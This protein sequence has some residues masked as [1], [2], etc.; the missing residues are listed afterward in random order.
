M[1]ADLFFPPCAFRPLPRAGIAVF[2]GIF[3]FFSFLAV[4]FCLDWAFVGFLPLH[5][6]HLVFHFYF[7]GPG[8]F[9]TPSIRRFRSFVPCPESLV[10]IFPF[11]SLYSPPE[12][13]FFFTPDS[14]SFRHLSP[15][16]LN[17]P[18]WSPITFSLPHLHRGTTEFFFFAF[19]SALRSRSPVPPFSCPPP[20]SGAP[21]DHLAYLFFSFPRWTPGGGAIILGC[22]GPSSDPIPTSAVGISS[23]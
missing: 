19:F 6:P 13:N 9:F 4:S 3:F 14:F 20:T 22:P 16:H 21:C 17:T 12:F 10:L 15:P 23:A 11:G 2:L 1:A 8:Q 7:N 18:T 5:P